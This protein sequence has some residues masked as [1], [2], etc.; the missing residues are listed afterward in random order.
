MVGPSDV[1]DELRLADERNPPAA[2]ALRGRR[3]ED[4]PKP[5]QSLLRLIAARPGF[6]AVEPLVVARCVDDGMTQSIELVARTLIHR[7][8]ARPPEDVADADDGRQIVR[9]EISEHQPEP[10]LFQHV[11]GR[12]THDGKGKRSG[13]VWGRWSQAAK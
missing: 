4:L 1:L 5:R 13:W 9:V 3:V 2:E 8:V 6:P 11:I 10:G 7:V 12:V